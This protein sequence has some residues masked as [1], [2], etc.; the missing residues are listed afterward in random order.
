MCRRSNPRAGAFRSSLRAARGLLAGAALALLLGPGAARAA[1]PEQLEVGLTAGG[2]VIRAVRVAAGTEDAPIVALV[3]GLDGADS[4]SRAVAEA[5][6]AFAAE[7]DD[8]RTFELL[9][10]P[11]ANAEANGLVFPPTG[12]AYR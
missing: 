5:V 8:E 1:E 6:E 7:P 3:A 9:A 4:A 11:V 10:V 12:A 2:D